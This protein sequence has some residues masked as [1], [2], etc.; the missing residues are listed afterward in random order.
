MEEGIKMFFIV[1]LLL[2]L[3]ISCFTNR[4]HRKDI[5]RAKNGRSRLYLRIPYWGFL[6]ITGLI[7]C[8]CV[9]LNFSVLGTEL[10]G[11]KIILNVNIAVLGIIPPLL[12]EAFRKW[13]DPLS[14]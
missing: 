14:D 2:T 11:V 1:G 7:L 9:M 4:D 6:G 3:Y 5:S 10:E 8:L 13:K 12:F